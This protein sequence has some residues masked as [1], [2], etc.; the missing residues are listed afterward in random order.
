VNNKLI[1]SAIQMVT[2]ASLENNLQ[3]AGDLI[4]QASAQGAQ[5]VALPEYFCMLGKKETD[6]LDIAET[7]GSGPIQ[8]FLAECAHK[9]KIWLSSGSIPMRSPEQGKVFNTQLVFNPQG[10]QVARYDKIHLFSFERGAESY[11]ESR[12]ILAGAT[13]QRLDTPDIHLGLSICYDL[14]FPE[15]YRAIGVV[16]LILVP[17]AFTYTTGQAHWE[18]LLRARA[19]ENQCYVL[20][21]AQG[22]LHENGRRT[23][24]HTMLIDPWGEILSVLPEQAGV[25]TGTI[26]P[27]RLSEVRQSLPALRHRTL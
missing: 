26:D 27:M 1:V 14:R 15:L 25:V 20:A 18:L 6:K 3:V 2:S 17:S 10:L 8:D 9:H 7:P 16:D 22:G 12:G 11:D 4:A 19:I 21:P 13:V 24:G 23:W 5:L